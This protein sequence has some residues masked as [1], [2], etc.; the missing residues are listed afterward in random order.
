MSRTK[1]AEVSIQAVS[2]ASTLDGAG[3]VGEAETSAAAV[4]PNAKAALIA[5]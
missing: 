5:K 4:C 3:G 2:P 1:A